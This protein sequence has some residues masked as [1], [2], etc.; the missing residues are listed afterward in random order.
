M[1]DNT[2]TAV[3]DESRREL[4]LELLERNPRNDAAYLPRDE[5]STPSPT[6]SRTRL[7][8]YHTHLPKLVE[9]G[10]VEWDKDD[11]ELTKGPEFDDVRPLLEFI[12]DRDDG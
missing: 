5:T 9:Y 12:A 10:Y 6:E 8:M 7:Q 1:N 3:A 4:L 2:Y 11:H